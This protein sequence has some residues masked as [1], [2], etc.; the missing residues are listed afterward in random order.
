MS[1][2]ELAMEQWTFA[3]NQVLARVETPVEVHLT[4]AYQKEVVSVSPDIIIPLK[5]NLR[6]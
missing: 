3:L 4:S 5:N 6:S 2:I 1:E